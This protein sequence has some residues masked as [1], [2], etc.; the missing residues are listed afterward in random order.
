MYTK[1]DNLFKIVSYFKLIVIYYQLNNPTNEAEKELAAQFQNVL[2]LKK[3]EIKRERMDTSH[4]SYNRRVHDDGDKRLA[5]RSSSRDTYYHESEKDTNQRPSSQRTEST[6]LNE[7]PTKRSKNKDDEHD[8]LYNKLNQ[9]DRNVLQ[10]LN[11]IVNDVE[12]VE[13]YKYSDFK[14][15]NVFLETPG[16][17]TYLSAADRQTLL[18]KFTELRNKNNTIN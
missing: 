6:A 16:S 17:A 4:S 18:K 13:N 9:D 8:K 2:Q 11:N 1:S 12:N 14:K 10:L 5:R 7:P 15:I 3:Q